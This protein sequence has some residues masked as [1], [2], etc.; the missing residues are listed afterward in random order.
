MRTLPVLVALALAAGGTTLGFNAAAL[1]ADG[2]SFA[3][4]DRRGGEPI[5]IAQATHA[6]DRAAIRG[7]ADALPRSQAAPALYPNQSVERGSQALRRTRNY[8]DS[9]AGPQAGDSSAWKSHHTTEGAEE[10]SAA[11]GGN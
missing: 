2:P 4:H 6:T 5:T 7:P 9:M 3:Q 1:Q 10:G 11:L 8:P